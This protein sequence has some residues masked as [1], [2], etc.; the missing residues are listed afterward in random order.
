MSSKIKLVLLLASLTALTP[1]SIDVYLP[2]LPVIA[3]DFQAGIHTLEL[4]LGIFLIGI[5]LGQLFGGALSDR[6][7]RRPV[8]LTG[9]SIYILATLLLTVTRH[10]EFF[11]IL[12]LVQAFGGGFSVVTTMA[13]IRDRYHGVEAAKLFALMGVIT[14][15]APLTAPGIGAFLLSSFGWRFIFGFLVL[16]AVF[17][18]ILLFTFLP[19]TREK[20]V[21]SAQKEPIFKEIFQRYKTVFSLRK[22]VGFILCQA[23]CMGSMFVFLTESSFVYITL[24]QVTPQ[25]YAILFAGNM[26][27]MMAFN[28]LTS[29]LL[30]RHPPLKILSLGLMVQ[31]SATGLLLLLTVIF[32]QPPLPVCLGLIMLS[33]GS[34]GLI[35]PNIMACYME[36]FS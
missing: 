15:I 30:N 29:W 31:F 5:A 6:F 18:L 22:A 25:T 7:G 36:F 28:R 35:T 2:A 14:M 34:L 23:F 20:D 21:P 33:V 10:V 13:I 26:L 12:R 1:F 11:L 9:L 27:T 3:E 8:A 19:E 24:Y 32:E 4:A 17:L 16:Y